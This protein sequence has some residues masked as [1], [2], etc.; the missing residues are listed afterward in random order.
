MPSPFLPPSPWLD[1]ATVL[2]D[3]AGVVGLLLGRRV[4]G[5]LDGGADEALELGVFPVVFPA[6]VFPTVVFPAVVFPPVALHPFPERIIEILFNFILVQVHNVYC[7]Q[8]DETHF[9]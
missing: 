5:L 4:P 9:A 2:T 7:H 8:G 6:V 1:G 3:V